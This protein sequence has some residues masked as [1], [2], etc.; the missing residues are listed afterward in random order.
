MGLLENLKL[1][2]WFVFM[3]RLL[4]LMD[5]MAIEAQR[6]F[7]FDGEIIFFNCSRADFSVKI[8]SIAWQGANHRVDSQQIPVLTA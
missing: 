4:F 7:L 3:A 5:S 8:F 6:T 2:I 1:H